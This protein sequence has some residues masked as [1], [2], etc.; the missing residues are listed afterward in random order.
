MPASETRVDHGCNGCIGTDSSADVLGSR[1]RNAAS[2]GHGCSRGPLELD[3]GHPIHSA[4]HLSTHHHDRGQSGSG[5][6][7]DSRRGWAGS[8]D[9]I[10]AL[11]KHLKVVLPFP[12]ASI[13]EV[14][15][16][17]PHSPAS[18]S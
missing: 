1:K 5:D 4:L 10:A 14:I 16:A 17:R 13:R 15:R 2:P 12:R 3:A 6:F 18:F 7:L 11:R 9:E 8:C